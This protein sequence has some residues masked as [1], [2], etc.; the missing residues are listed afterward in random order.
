MQLHVYKCNT[1]ISKFS[2]RHFQIVRIFLT[3]IYEIYFVCPILY[4]IL[5]HE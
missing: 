1:M 3:L 4:I 2:V 5:I